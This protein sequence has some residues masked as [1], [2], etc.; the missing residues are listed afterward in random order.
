MWLSPEEVSQLMK[1]LDGW[2]IN[3]RGHLYKEYKFSDFASAM[4]F[5]N[6]VSKI[7]EREYH[8]PNINISWGK[9]RLEIWTHSTNGLTE[10]D[11][12]LAAKVD[13]E[14]K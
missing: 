3:S 12:I 13:Y 9:C 5:A 8:H 7:A 6:K 2:L 11:F 4:D 14:I 1:E 10:N